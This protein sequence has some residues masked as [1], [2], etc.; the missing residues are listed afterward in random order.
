MQGPTVLLDS[1][2]PV[3]PGLGLGA[4]RQYSFQARHSVGGFGQLLKWRF[5]HSAAAHQPT[6]GALSERF[7]QFAKHLDL[8]LN[9]ALAASLPMISGTRR[10]AAAV[11][12]ECP[13]IRSVPAVGRRTSG[14]DALWEWPVRARTALHRTHPADRNRR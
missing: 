3:T 4:P 8:V 2:R 10:I 6:G 12:E 11:E 7:A 13:R 1:L 9:R 14:R 5:W